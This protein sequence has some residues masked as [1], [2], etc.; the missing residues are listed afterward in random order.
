SVFKNLKKNFPG[1]LKDMKFIMPT[2]DSRLRYEIGQWLKAKELSV[3]IIAET[4]DI[5]LKKQMAV[6]K[7][8]LIPAAR[9]TVKSLV[10]A[11]VLVEI[12]IVE[13]AYEEIFLISANRKIANPISK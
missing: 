13:E 9:H 10:K 3:D 4:Q 1:S 6:E 7:I 12:G 8:G 11:G 5:A 2:F